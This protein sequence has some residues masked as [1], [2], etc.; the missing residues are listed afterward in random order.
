MPLTEIERLLVLTACAGTTGWHYAI[1]RHERYA[2]H[3]SNY[4]GGAAGRT[5]PS[6][7]GFHTA[8]IF[9]TDDTGTYFFPTARRAARR[10]IPANERRDAC[11][12]MIERHRHADPPARPT[13]RMYLPQPA[14]RTWRATT[15]GSPTARARCW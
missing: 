4:S 10:S 8:E 5:F 11:E 1:T 2:P 12:L 15:R 3:L 7:A 6:A 14:S 13:Q 9:F